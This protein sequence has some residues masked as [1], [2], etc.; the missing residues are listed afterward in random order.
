MTLN[1][2]NRYSM[3]RT[4]HQ[5]ADLAVFAELCPIITVKFT[6][7]LISLQQFSHVSNE[8]RKCALKSKWLIKMMV[9]KNRYIIV[10]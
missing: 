8:M 9:L 6:L 10:I 4:E 5:S 3:Q 2:V 7:Q 1:Q